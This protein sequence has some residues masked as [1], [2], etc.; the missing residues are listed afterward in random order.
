LENQISPPLLPPTI[1]VL[2][3]STEASPRIAP[4]LDLYAISNGIGAN[5][6][7]AAL[8]SDL[9]HVTTNFDGDHFTDSIPRWFTL[10]RRPPDLPSFRIRSPQTVV[11]V[12]FM[13]FLTAGDFV[14]H[15]LTS[16]AFR[17][18]TAS[19]SLLFAELPKP[20]DIGSNARISEIFQPT[21]TICCFH[22][23]I[24]FRAS[25]APHAIVPTFVLSFGYNLHDN[26]PPVF[27][28]VALILWL[29]DCDMRRNLT[30]TLS[31]CI[32]FFFGYKASNSTRITILSAI[33]A[34]QFAA[35]CAVLA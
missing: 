14:R 20:P 9:R 3:F 33:S 22:L 4:N 7:Q 17:N 30:T 32:Y 8:F 2:S 1:P 27:P 35:I 23:L 11:D 24:T 13:H 16:S 18:L 15:L 6:D 10:Q 28:P 31:P 29:V 5:N 21:A 12:P 19:A 25:S 34:R 26:M